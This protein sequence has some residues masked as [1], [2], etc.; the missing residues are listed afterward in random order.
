VETV[1]GKETLQATVG[2]TYQNVLQ[3]DEQANSNPVA[4]RE[5]R[6]RRS[7][8]GNEREIPAF[9]KSFH[10]AEFTSPTAAATSDT[11]GSALSTQARTT[12]GESD[13]C[14]VHL[15]VLDLHWFWKLMEGNYFIVRRIYEQVYRG[16]S[17]TSTNLLHGSNIQI[18]HKK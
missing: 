1:D 2:H 4:F 9:K 8:V 13:E 10:S 16:P 6:N 7:F 11:V 15:K 3:D 18:S 5:K 14:H 17:A 12:V